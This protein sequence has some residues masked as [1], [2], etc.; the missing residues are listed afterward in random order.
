MTNSASSSTSV[1]A[2]TFTTPT[3]NEGVASRQDS[4]NSHINSV[5]GANDTSGT[6]HRNPLR[7][8]FRRSPHA[9][10]SSSLYNANTQAEPSQSA[11]LNHFVEATNNPSRSST[12]KKLHNPLGTGKRFEEARQAQLAALTEYQ[13]KYAATLALPTAEEIEKIQNEHAHVRES[14]KHYQNTRGA[15]LEAQELTTKNGNVCNINNTQQTILTRSRNNIYQSFIE[16]LYFTCNH[17]KNLVQLKLNSM[18][19]NLGY[20]NADIEKPS[21]EQKTAVC[22]LLSG[23]VNGNIDVA[24]VM[25][26]TAIHSDNASFR[27]FLI[28]L[29]TNIDDIKKKSNTLERNTERNEKLQRK[30]FCKGQV[31][32]PTGL[33]GGAGALAGTIMAIAGSPALGAEVFAGAIADGLAVGIPAG[34]LAANFQNKDKIEIIKENT[35]DIRQLIDGSNVMPKYSYALSEARNFIRLAAKNNNNDADASAS[36]DIP[37]MLTKKLA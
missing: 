33:I 8:L 5:F 35:R 27:D 24:S 11:T 26:H 14:L 4:N 20:T 10:Q 29:D 36:T 9:H 12:R 6:R 30:N 7:N 19:D 2:R 18:L 25:A 28:G 3:T 34:F 37:E 21:D 13:E 17:D 23:L 32:L 15:Q 22:D 31:A 16:A 1:R